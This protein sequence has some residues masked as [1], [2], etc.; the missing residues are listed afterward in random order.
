MLRPP[1]ALVAGGD[2][3][4]KIE[5]AI[6]VYLEVFRQLLGKDAS[7]VRRLR[8]LHFVSRFG[9]RVAVS[10]GELNGDGVVDWTRRALYT[11]LVAHDSGSAQ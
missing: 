9:S 7:G 2:V 1:G 11:N 3:L 8:G 10:I 5:G 6:P 4:H